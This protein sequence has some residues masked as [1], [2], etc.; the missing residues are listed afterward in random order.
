MLSTQAPNPTNLG[1]QNATFL[2]LGIGMMQGLLCGQS[3]MINPN[4]TG[5]DY[6]C[7]PTALKT[8][9]VYIFKMNSRNNGAPGGSFIATNYNDPNQSYI[10]TMLGDGSYPKWAPIGLGGSNRPIVDIMLGDEVFVGGVYYDYRKISPPAGYVLTAAYQTQA[11]EGVYARP[12]LV[13]VAGD[14]NWYIVRQGAG[15]NANTDGRYLRSN[16]GHN[17]YVYLPIVQGN[18]FSGSALPAV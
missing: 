5:N 2:T 13:K 9:W 15:I 6:G 12:I 1:T 10:G 8:A 14:S 18:A 4:D 11:T 7:L 3:I 17:A 16:G